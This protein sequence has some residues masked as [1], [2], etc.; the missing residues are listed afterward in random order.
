MGQAEHDVGAL[1]TSIGLGKSSPATPR[2]V[3]QWARWVV[4]LAVVFAAM[5]PVVLTIRSGTVGFS[6][7][8]LA[9]GG[10]LAVLSGSW[11]V[12][13]NRITGVIVVTMG[14]AVL[15]LS[16]VAANA[17]GELV[18]DLRAMIGLALTVS[19]LWLVADHLSAQSV[20]VATIFSAEIGAVWVAS[21]GGLSLAV[22]GFWIAAVTAG[23]WLL[24]LHK[25]WTVSR[26]VVTVLSGVIMLDGATVLGPYRGW[27]LAAALVVGVVLVAMAWTGPAMATRLGA[28]RTGAARFFDYH[29]GFFVPLW[30]WRF[31]IDAVDIDNFDLSGLGLGSSQATLKDNLERG[32]YL[33][34]LS[35]WTIQRSGWIGLVLAGVFALLV[36]GSDSPLRS[37][38]VA[39]RASAVLLLVGVSIAV[40]LDDAP[41][42][43][44]LPVLGVAIPI[45]ALLFG[46]WLSKLGM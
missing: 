41:L 18:S 19:A 11:L 37:R 34:M 17:S 42:A 9:A 2:L 33:S 23:F 21:D 16:A 24:A 15:P 44:A 43:I 30:F 36:L 4:P 22:V 12:S 39:V 29:V 46:F 28:P 7:A 13:S 14:A 40:L 3:G 31:A 38:L 27:D 10:G 26:L 1:T 6:L 8:L 32:E 45:G 5:L 25:T 20:A 35:H